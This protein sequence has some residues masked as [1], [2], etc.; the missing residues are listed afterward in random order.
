MYSV[1]HF[2]IRKQQSHWSIRPKS[3]AV[4]Y[5][6][7]R[8]ATRV[9]S[10]EHHRGPTAVHERQ[11]IAWKDTRRWH[12]TDCAQRQVIIHRCSD[13]QPRYNHRL[14][15]FLLRSGKFPHAENCIEETWV[16]PYKIQTDCGSASVCIFK[17]NV[18]SMANSK[19]L[20]AQCA[21]LWKGL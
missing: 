20:T 13:Q 15:D 14:K 21:L 16:F 10:A 12:H 2:R 17:S 9:D 11:N 7:T 8:Q 18:F 3:T 6:D 1:F 19:L 5:K 4:N